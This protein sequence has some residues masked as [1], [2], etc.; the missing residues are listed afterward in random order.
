VRPFAWG[1]AAERR[2]GPVATP[3]AAGPRVR[4]IELVRLLAVKPA[5]PDEDLCQPCRFAD[6]KAVTGTD[7]DERLDSAECFNI[8]ALQ[9]RREGA[10][11]QGQIQV[12]GMSS[13]IPRR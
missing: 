10:I 6:H 12:R 9:L 3:I 1:C 7:L 13:G 2:A 4:T 5:A 8:F 11:P